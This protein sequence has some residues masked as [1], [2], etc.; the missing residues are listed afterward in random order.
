MFAI[1][2]FI[3]LNWNTMQSV[4]VQEVQCILA[5]GVRFNGF[6]FR[7]IQIGYFVIPP[8]MIVHVDKILEA[9]R[10]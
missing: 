3:I 8:P 7:H 4:Y 9:S 6:G 10:L 2:P 5:S 1:L